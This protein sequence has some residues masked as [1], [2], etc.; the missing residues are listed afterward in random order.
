M[1]QTAI[2][3]A[4]VTHENVDDFLHTIQA[5]DQHREIKIGDLISHYRDD[6]DETEVT[7]WHKQRRAAVCYYNSESEWGDWDE[8]LQTITLDD[9]NWDGTRVT[10]G[11]YG[12]P[13]NTEEHS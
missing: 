1:I 4:R 8:R 10:L 13:C 12:K 11:R 9:A 2:V 6:G 5:H 7:I 3:R